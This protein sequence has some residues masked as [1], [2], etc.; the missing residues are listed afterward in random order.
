[1]LI[2]IVAINILCFLVMC[3]DK[4]M[5]RVRKYR[6]P[7]VRLLLLAA[8]GGS[9]GIYLGMHILKHKTQKLIFSLGVPVILFIQ[10]IVFRMLI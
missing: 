2:Y 3:Y 4:T 10:I 7:E 6:V 5:A 8:A 1:M 9:I